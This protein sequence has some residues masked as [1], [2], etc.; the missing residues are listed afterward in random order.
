MSYL[1]IGSAEVNTFALGGKSQLPAPSSEFAPP[2]KRGN[3]WPPSFDNEHQAPHAAMRRNVATIRAYRWSDGSHE[4]WVKG[5]LMFANTSMSRPSEPVRLASL[6]Q[7]N[8][9]NGEAAQLYRAASS[10][11][12]TPE[13]EV[14]RRSLEA[15]AHMYAVTP[16]EIFARWK[17]IGVFDTFQAKPRQGSQTVVGV[18]VSHYCQVR[19][20]FR[21][22]PC[23]G[24]KLILT[25]A[26]FSCAKHPELGFGSVGDVLQFVPEIDSDCVLG[27]TN[28][29]IA[30]DIDGV[31]A[32][33]VGD[34]TLTCSTTFRLYESDL[35]YE[36]SSTGP[37]GI[38]YCAPQNGLPS[39]E[40]LFTREALEREQE[41]FNTLRAPSV[42]PT[43][44]ERTVLAGALYVGTFTQSPDSGPT[45]GRPF[46]HMLV[47]EKLAAKTN[48]VQFAVAQ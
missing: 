17:F 44:L 20:V 30:D 34:T 16:E 2:T 25:L 3:N 33:A 7:V 5:D 23:P 45:I 6:Q 47:D 28:S 41:P 8:R 13:R 22:E 14:A 9:Y 32:P 27:I 26:R 40:Y 21:R 11:I 39:D 18:A 4:N 12:P 10:P 24:D 15:K 29:S 1:S 37:D 36:T 46:T 48:L 35:K 43:P 19:D 42:I 38:V 31:P